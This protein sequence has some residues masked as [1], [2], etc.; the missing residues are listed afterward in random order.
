MLST[1]TI[2]KQSTSE[3]AH[4]HRQLYAIG[5]KHVQRLARRI[6]TDYNVH[7]PGVTI[8]ELLSYALTDLGYRASFPVKDLLAY[9]MDPDF[10]IPSVMTAVERRLQGRMIIRPIDRKNRDRDLKAMC[11]IFNDAWENNWGFVPFTDEEFLTI[12]HEM[13]LIINDDFIQIADCQLAVLIEIFDMCADFFQ[14]HQHI[15]AVTIRVHDL[16]NISNRGGMSAG[17][18]RV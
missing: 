10:K 14:R 16:R 17:V 13:L 3:P 8:L 6:W 2:P 7:D 5:L 12:G 1:L 18:N 9:E 15:V 4:D 11:G